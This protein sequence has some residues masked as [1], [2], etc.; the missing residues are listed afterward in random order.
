[1]A[2]FN[3]NRTSA[4]T[5]RPRVSRALLLLSTRCRGPSLPD[6]N[7]VHGFRQVGGDAGHDVAFEKI[8]QRSAAAAAKDDGVHTEGGSNVNDGVRRRITD[9]VEF[10]DL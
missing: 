10:V 2:C 3:R 1:M 4:R 7:K 8:D 9:A 5:P 6:D